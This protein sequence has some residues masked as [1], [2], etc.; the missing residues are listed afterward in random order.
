MNSIDFLD[1]VRARHNIP[2]DNK[3]A[4][5]L[6]MPQGRISLVRTG[7]RKIDDAMALK[8]ADALDEPAG[9]VL[10]SIQAERA[11]DSEISGTWRALAER[12]H[13]L[14]K[15]AAAGLALLALAICTPSPTQA[16]DFKTVS[17]SDVQNNVYYGKW[18][19]YLVKRL[20]ALLPSHA[21]EIR[22]LIVTSGRP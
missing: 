9:Y 21:T 8:I 12:I 18:L 15:G 11:N 10:A 4:A 7:A 22:E 19:R 2:S 14:G 1:A 20:A 16:A 5:F 17:L 3:L 13:D 6:D